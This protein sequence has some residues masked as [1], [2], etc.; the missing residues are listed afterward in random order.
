MTTADSRVISLADFRASRGC[1]RPPVNAWPEGLKHRVSVVRFVP[2]IYEVETVFCRDA[3]HAANV[4]MEAVKS[5]QISAAAHE[6]GSSPL[7]VSAITQIVP[8][9]VRERIPLAFRA[10]RLCHDWLWSFGGR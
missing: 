4:A 7:V 8:F 6:P 5:G 3:E 2:I 1:E 9:N 10:A